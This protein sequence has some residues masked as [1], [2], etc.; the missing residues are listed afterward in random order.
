M[1]P[2]QVVEDFRRCLL[3]FDA[4]AERILQGALDFPDDPMVLLCAAAFYLYGQ[5]AEA[6]ATA[7]SF[8]DRAER[9]GAGTVAPYLLKALRHWHAQDY[10]AAASIFE[11]ATTADPRDLLAAKFCEFIYYIRGQQYSGPRFL[12]HM[13]RLAPVNGS[14]PDFLAMYSFAQELCGNYAAARSLAE[15]SIGIE[16]RNPWAEHTL[17]HVTIRL[18]DIAEGENRL[19]KFLPQAATCSRPIHSHTAWHLALFDLERLDYGD[20]LQLF[21][22]HIW[23]IT[24][25]MIG[26]QVDAIALLWRMEMAGADVTSEW[27][28]IADHVEPHVEECFMPFLSAHHAYALTR[29]GRGNA[30]EK[31]HATVGAQSPPLWKAIGAPVVEATVSYGRGEWKKAAEQL[32]PVMDQMTAIGGSDAQDDLFRQ[33]YFTALARAGQKTKARDYFGLHASG[34]KASA[35]DQYFQGLF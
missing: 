2:E 1:S 32:A 9:C 24:P 16:A 10:E 6:N 21:R 3:R 15:K 7:A 4:G 14:D 35:L 13:E 28:A 25:D 23:G 12:A 31:L 30:A 27:K 8:L 20:A 17:S 29:A 19:R 34:K 33:M 5:T 18:G 26:E 11:A 22:A